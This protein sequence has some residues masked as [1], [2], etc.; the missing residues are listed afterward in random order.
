LAPNLMFWC[1]AAINHPVE[2][3]Q[4]FGYCFHNCVAMM[5]N[6]GYT[7]AGSYIKFDFLQQYLK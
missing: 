6:C 1:R 7:T 4:V 3:V 5:S 2:V